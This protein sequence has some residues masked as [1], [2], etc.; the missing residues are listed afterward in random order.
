MHHLSI[1]SLWKRVG[2]KVGHPVGRLNSGI[3]MNSEIEKAGDSPGNMKEDRHIERSAE[4]TNHITKLR[5]E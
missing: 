3:E 1:K 5:L 2:E 4:V